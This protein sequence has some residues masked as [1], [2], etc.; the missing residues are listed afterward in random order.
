MTQSYR[1]RKSE[2]LTSLKEIQALFTDGWSFH[3]FPFRVL[4]KFSDIPDNSSAQIVVSVPKRKYKKAVTRNLIRRR[5]KEGYRLHKQ[6]LYDQ[7]EQDGKKLVF[8]LMYTH[9]EILTFEEIE[10]K[11]SAMLLRLKKEVKDKT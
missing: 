8:M 11:I 4:W 1:F 7:L 5:I 6:I 2:R 3:S 10:S 9:S